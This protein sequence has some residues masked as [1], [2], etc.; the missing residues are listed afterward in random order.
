MSQ[1][2]DLVSAWGAK[3]RKLGDG[4]RSLLPAAR[5]EKICLEL[6]A[7]ELKE[8]LAR[9]R[10]DL[11]KAPP[12]TSLDYLHTRDLKAGINFPIELCGNA[13]ACWPGSYSDVAVECV[14]LGTRY[15]LGLKTKSPNYRFVVKRFGVNPSDWKG[16]CFLRVKQR[17]NKPEFLELY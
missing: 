17:G 9:E 16:N 2:D 12:P 7:R 10:T 1:L 11:E 13:R 8:A 3:A 6:C 5:A 4:G 15:L 14:V